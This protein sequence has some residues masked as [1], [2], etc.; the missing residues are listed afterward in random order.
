MI[1][2]QLSNT[3]GVCW[4]VLPAA[5]WLKLCPGIITTI[6]RETLTGVFNIPQASPVRTGAIDLIPDWTGV[7]RHSN[8]HLFAGFVKHLR[9]I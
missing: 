4:L 6:P 2:I 1:Q 9:H 8:I 3:Q 7:I 5:W